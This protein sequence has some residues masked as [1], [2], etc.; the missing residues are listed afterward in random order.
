MENLRYVAFMQIPHTQPSWSKTSWVTALLATLWLG[1]C[2][3]SLQPPPT[4][5]QLKQG[6]SVKQSGQRLIHIAH[7]LHRL[8][9]SHHS[10]TQAILAVHGFESR[11]YEW[12]N[13]LHSFA[14][15]GAHVFWLRWQWDQCPENAVKQLEEA[16]RALEKTLPAIESIEIFGHSYGGVISAMFAQN[17]PT[18]RPLKIHAIASPLAG[19]GKMELVCAK[20]KLGQKPYPNNVTMTQW[21]TI[22]ILDGAFKDLEIDPQIIDLKGARIVNLPD[23]F[24]GHR[25]GHNWSVS[26]VA[27]NWLAAMSTAGSQSVPVAK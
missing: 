17:P 16:V 12:V 11:G 26:Y 1:A 10:S 8:T 6:E 15:S 7:G 4:L 23:T 9:P 13:A 18:K 21:R 5:D 24:N 22:H 3:P 27:K 19:M 25:L 2:Q 14:A 20:L